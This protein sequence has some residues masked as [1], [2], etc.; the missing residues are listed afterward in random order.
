MTFIDFYMHKCDFEKLNNNGINKIWLITYFIQK[1]RVFH[2]KC[3]VRI[4]FSYDKN[5]E[6]I[7]F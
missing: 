2:H 3:N 5:N 7:M 4:V 6:N 1:N